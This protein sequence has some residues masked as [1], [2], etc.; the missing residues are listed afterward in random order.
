MNNGKKYARYKV[1]LYF[2]SLAPLLLLIFLLT[3][4]LPC[5][6]GLSEK[7]G[8]IIERFCR[9]VFPMLSGILGGLSLLCVIFV[10]RGW[11]KAQGNPNYTI[12]KIENL[13][14][15]YLTFLTTYTIPLV[16]MDLT[17]LRYII[18]LILLLGVMG[19]LFIRTDLYY[20]NPTLALMGYRLYRAT[21]S[22]EKE[23]TKV[24]LITK[25]KLK[26][27]DSIDWIPIDEN[28]WVARRKN[29]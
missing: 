16:C 24:V 2:I 7:P 20:G 5:L 13:N 17:N 4:Y 10:D 8:T 1:A 27:L 14:Y 26:E 3:I 21:L 15:E 22:G 25:T 29:Q 6:D 28:V 12:Q 23:E 19:F 9:I 18:V 11:E